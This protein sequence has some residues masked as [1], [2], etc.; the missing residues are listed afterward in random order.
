TDGSIL[1]TV[2]DASGA[3][4]PGAAVDVV[5]LD[6]GIRQTASTNAVGA[7]EILALG[8][9]FY[10]VTVTAKG[11]RPWTLE[12]IELAA[13]QQ[14][15]VTAALEVGEVLER[16]I[17][18]GAA[19]LLQTEK[20]SLEAAIAEKQIRD[21]PLIGRDPIE[22]VNLVPGLRYLGR[23]GLSGESTVQGAGQ[24]D[25]QTGFSVD[26]LDANDASTEKGVGLPALE[27]V[28]QFSV[29]TSNFTAESGRM[30]LQ[31][32]LIT[33]GGSNEFHGTLWEY[34]RNFAV[35]AR[36]TF[37]LATPKLIRNQF[38]YG[39]GG[40]LRRNR[41][42]FFSSF[43]GS[44]IRRERIYNADTIDPA[45]REGDFRPAPRAIADPAAN[46]PFP[47]NQI[48]V[49]RI[50]SASRFFYPHILMPN[51][52]GENRYRA[53]A[54]SLDDG[55]NF[56][57]RLDYQITG[58][59]RAYARWIRISQSTL[60]PQYR[61]EITSSQDL[62][63]H[64]AA[65]NYNWTITPSTLLNLAFGYLQSQTLN[66]SDAVGKENLTAKA[67]IQGIPTEGREEAVGLPNVTF[68]GYQGFSMP[69]QVPGN[70]RR[71]DH[72]GKAGMSLVR[73]NHTLGFG[74]EYND[75][76]T[77]AAHSSA[78][79]RGTFGFNGQ[80]TN[81]GFADYVLGLVANNERNY[82]L[83]SFGMGHSP[84]SA[85]YAQDFW[86]VSRSLTLTLGLR[87]DYWH[88]KTLVRNAGAT[89]DLKTGRIAA[90]NDE[91]GRIDLTSQPV[92]PYLAASTK[93]LWAPAAMLNIPRGLFQAGGFLTPRLGVAWRP[94]HKEDW[95]V[96]AGFGIFASSYNGNI[97]GSQ[98]IGPP[99]WAVERST[100]TRASMQRWETSFPANPRDFVQPSVTA[101]AWDVDPMRSYQMN[102]SIQRLLPLDSA[103]TVSYAGNRGRDLI[104]R[105]DH[106]EAPPGRYTN[107]Q[108]ARPF[109]AL[110][111]LRLYENIGR[112]WYNSLQVQWERRFTRGLGYGATYVF[113][114]QVDEF[115]DSITDFP[116]PFAP[117]GYNRGRSD[118]ERRHMVTSNAIYEIPIARGRPLIGGW[119][120][121][122]IYTFISGEPLT[123][124]VPGATLGN[125]FNTRPNLAGAVRVP[126]PSP[127][128]WFNPAGL[129]APPLYQFGNSGLGILDGPG[130]HNFNTGL[131]KYFA[132]RE[133]MRFQF[134]WELFN[135]INH[136]NLASPVTTLGQANTA[137]I[138]AAGEPRRMQFALK[139]IF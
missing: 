2:H 48:P 95:V 107:L 47:N 112:S 70:F 103:L 114:R 60:N 27:T 108:A 10:S 131:M 57:L 71:Q 46:A 21:L 120:L 85:A 34:H 28:E 129:A 4:V 88:E 63:Q 77:L 123:F 26:G 74:Y 32:M 29:Q 7:F 15:R 115:G 18:R 117:A 106:N 12:R 138:R 78:S 113:A 83:Q 36:N 13:G 3:S 33:K 67:G 24:R 100:F 62:V 35:D 56:H 58:S 9:G 39:L 133:R 125:G 17:V 135:V 44:R 14:R 54:P 109:P 122:G 110:G 139:F 132:V 59:Q 52:P 119:Q 16:V 96:R 136:V 45:M 40:P 94:F 130:N 124:T 116:V 22:L 121:S 126:D 101:A 86:K 5:S 61:P 90:A 38:G 102:V 81:N 137:K 55:G 111:T 118:L 134:R 30:P 20:A 19:D 89:F 31:V 41:L 127:E 37:A 93:D 25:D 1:G 82:P 42:F 128:G 65:L 104:T 97:T 64:N 49:S 66:N 69:S 43:E 6:R 105:V 51:V 50:S 98:I 91:Q 80:Y 68:T 84:Y 79:P 8:R 87:W 92:A 75:R 73:R 11:F 72:H 53:V 23:G 76:R 99:Y